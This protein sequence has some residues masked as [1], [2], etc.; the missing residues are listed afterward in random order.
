MEKK[1]SNDSDHFSTNPKTHPKTTTKMMNILQLRLKTLLIT[2]LLSSK[3][4]MAKSFVT[5]GAIES[6][7][8]LKSAERTIST[9]PLSPMIYHSNNSMKETS[10]TCLKAL[11][12][13]AGGFVSL[14][15]LTSLNYFFKKYPYVAAFCICKFCNI[16]SSHVQH[17]DFDINKHSNIL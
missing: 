1:T 13:R 17:D 12:L 11:S 3:A 8:N 7:V 6:L 10:T 5:S 16:S 4:S 15:T 9:N 14:P 2:L